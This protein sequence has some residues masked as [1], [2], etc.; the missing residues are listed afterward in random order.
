MS[1]LETRHYLAASR[2][3]CRAPIDAAEAGGRHPRGTH[4]LRRRRIARGGQGRRNPVEGVEN[5]KPEL[6]GIF[7]VDGEIA[8]Y[9]KLLKLLRGFA[10]PAVV[11]V[12]LE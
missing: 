2:G 10:L 5:F 7:L 8:A 3:G 11:V 4:G 9:A 12:V 1:E 6:D